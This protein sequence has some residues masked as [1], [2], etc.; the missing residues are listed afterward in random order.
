MN[1]SQPRVFRARRTVLA[2]PGS[3]ERFIEKSRGLPVDALFLD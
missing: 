2:V 1:A 3:S